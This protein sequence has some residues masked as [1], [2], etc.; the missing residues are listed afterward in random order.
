ML[1][2]DLDTRVT[3]SQALLD[4]A[5]KLGQKISNASAFFMPFLLSL[6]EQTL[7]RVHKRSR[8]FEI[9]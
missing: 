4:R 5:G 9:F 8:G 7:K 3:S 1:Q 6:E 2:A